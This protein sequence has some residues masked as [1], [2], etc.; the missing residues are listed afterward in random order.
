MKI[1][2]TTI[3]EGTNFNSINPIDELHE[4]IEWRLCAIQ[5]ALMEN[6]MEDTKR[7]FPI[8][9]GIGLEFLKASYI[10]NKIERKIVIAGGDHNDLNIYLYKVGISNDMYKNMSTEFNLVLYVEN[11]KIALVLVPS[12][13]VFDLEKEI[14]NNKLLFIP[15]ER[16]SFFYNYKGT[17]VPDA[18]RVCV[19]KPDFAI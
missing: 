15:H 10:Y 1:N 3:I 18:T 19:D 6:N 14:E 11:K 7:L 2:N 9:R 4:L 8:I 5:E 12:E 17:K 16:D 13:N